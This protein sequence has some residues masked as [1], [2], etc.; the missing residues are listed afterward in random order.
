LKSKIIIDPACAILVHGRL[1]I[2]L[3]DTSLAT[4]P[5]PTRPV[6]IIIIIAGSA[7]PNKPFKLISNKYF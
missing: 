1:L 4:T 2:Y 5:I 7:I 6:P 3:F